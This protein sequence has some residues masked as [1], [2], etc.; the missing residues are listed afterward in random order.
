MQV[1]ITNRFDRQ[2]QTNNQNYLE[3]SGHRNIELSFQRKCISRRTFALP[4]PFPVPILILVRHRLRQLWRHGNGPRRVRT[5]QTHPGQTDQEQLVQSPRR[6]PKERPRVQVERSRRNVAAKRPRDRFTLGVGIR[7]GV[8][9]GCPVAPRRRRRRMHG[10]GTREARKEQQA[11][12]LHQGKAREKEGE[13]GYEEQVICSDASQ[14]AGPLNA[15]RQAVKWENA[16][17][18]LA[19][20]AQPRQPHHSCTATVSNDSRTN[21]SPFQRMK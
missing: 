7:I 10:Q 16:S 2:R 9:Y 6:H 1:F 11:Q 8:C 17:P 12:A 21:F 18:N 3:Q 14:P 4:Y 13:A 19:V 5:S 15:V 20:R